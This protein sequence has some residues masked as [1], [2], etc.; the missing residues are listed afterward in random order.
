MLRK[1]SVRKLITK[2]T[3]ITVKRRG[4]RIAKPAEKIF[5]IVKP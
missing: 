3:I 5:F 2:F 1:G 4:R